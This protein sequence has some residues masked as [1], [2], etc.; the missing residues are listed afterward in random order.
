MEIFLVLIGTV[1]VA[2][3]L[4]QH[5]VNKR[6]SASLLYLLG[7]SFIFLYGVL[8]IRKGGELFVGGM[9]VLIGLLFLGLAIRM[10]IAT[11]RL[12]SRKRNTHTW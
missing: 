11:R 9:I 7:G 10:V 2:G 6:D 12:N 1:L 8:N 3:G 5:R 4:L